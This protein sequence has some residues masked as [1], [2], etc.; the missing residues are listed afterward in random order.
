M[1]EEEPPRRLVRWRDRAEQEV[2]PSGFQPQQPPSTARSV[3]EQPGPPP[4]GDSLLLTARGTFA[5][6]S[7]GPALLGFAG[8]LIGGLFLGIPAVIIDN[9]PSG[10]D[11]STGAQI[12]AQVATVIGF[13][14]A[15]LIVS[16]QFGGGSLKDIL[17]R[18]GVRKFE[19]GAV[20]WMVGAIVV[21]LV[22]AALYSTLVTTPRQED[23]ADSFGPVWV[24][25]LLIVVAAAT[26]E[27]I[28]FRGMLFGGFAKGMPLWLAIVLSGA[29]FGGLHAITGV[30]AVPPLMVFGMILAFLYDRTG[31]ILPGM[32]LHALNNSLA[33]LGQ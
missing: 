32:I 5:T 15:A 14:G 21:Y 24:Q 20:V 18:L 22:F 11:L 2:P 25:V 31:S 8:A 23:I 27:E 29:I 30:T 12:A 1:S 26:T 28:C 10:D 33:L 16:A 9:P 3:G 17:G 6:W 19:P 13:L 4:E 7:Y